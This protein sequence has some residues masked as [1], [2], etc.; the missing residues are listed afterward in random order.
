MIH[1]LQSILTGQRPPGIYRFT[2][3]AYASSIGENIESSGWRCFYINAEGV[4]DKA[5]FLTATAGTMHFPKYFGSNWDAFEECLTDLS[6]APALGY[7][8]L[9]D[10]IGAF[11]RSS[12]TDWNTAI[13]IFSD[14]VESWKTMSLPMYVLLRRAGR[15]V[16]YLPKL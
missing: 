5:S 1:G 11:V 6:W 2:S 14:A 7:V 3:R 4:F 10:N 13:A 8:V 12:P 9:I 16:G 15:R